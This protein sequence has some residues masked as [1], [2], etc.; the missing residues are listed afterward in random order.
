MDYLLPNE[1]STIQCNS[2]PNMQFTMNNINY[3]AKDILYTLKE[4][5]E[6]TNIHVIDIT[7]YPINTYVK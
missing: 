1:S 3:L 2:I 7:F 6:Y 4:N 5:K